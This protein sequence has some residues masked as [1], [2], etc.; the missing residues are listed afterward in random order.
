MRVPR[1]MDATEL[2]KSLMRLG[3][4]V[5]RQT[6]SHIRMTIDIPR[7]HHVTIPNHSPLKIGTLNSVLTEVAN[8]FRL[9]RDELMHRILE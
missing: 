9:S 8:H 2:V 7:Q 3:Y 5:T 1:D 4:R 6:G